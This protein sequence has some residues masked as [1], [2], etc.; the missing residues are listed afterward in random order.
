M[1]APVRFPRRRRRPEL[2]QRIL[3]H[4]DKPCQLPASLF[5]GCA[6]LS[7]GR[8][9]V[10]P[11]PVDR[12]IGVENLFIG[13]ARVTPGLC[14][15]MD[16]VRYF[17]G[18][19]LHPVWRNG[20]SDLIPEFGGKF[21]LLCRQFFETWPSLR[22]CKRPNGVGWLIAS[23]RACVGASSICRTLCRPEEHARQYRAQRQ[24]GGCSAHSPPACWGLKIPRINPMLTLQTAFIVLHTSRRFAPRGLVP[25]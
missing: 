16:D 13:V 4:R 21:V 7:L 8:N 20:R 23:V 6:L 18:E 19:F 25:F 10:A 24:H 9:P 17:V 11:S 14:V 5:L 1:R 15:S 22:L 12:L 3:Q 2:A